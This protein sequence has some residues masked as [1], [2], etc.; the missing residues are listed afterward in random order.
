MILFNDFDCSTN[1]PK[2]HYTKT[3]KPVII[4]CSLKPAPLF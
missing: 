4:N 2:I 1:L 3:L